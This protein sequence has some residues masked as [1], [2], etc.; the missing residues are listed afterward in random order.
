M[1]LLCFAKLT[2]V[3]SC[4]QS[5]SH[6]ALDELL[7]FRPVAYECLG[8]PGMPRQTSLHFQIRVTLGAA[9]ALMVCHM[10]APARVPNPR[11]LLL[12]CLAAVL[13]LCA[14]RRAVTDRASRGWRLR[15]LIHAFL[16][17]LHAAGDLPPDNRLG[18]EPDAAS[19]THAA[20][21]DW[22]TVNQRRI[23]PACS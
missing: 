1:H 3:S 19:L 8:W 14:W 4:S 13:S 6:T 16:Q 17:R 15:Q 9:A 7:S 23:S 18:S 2:L 22:T 12:Q 10:E 11:H 21:P 5:L 20:A